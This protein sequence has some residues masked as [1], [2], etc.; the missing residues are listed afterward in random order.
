MDFL[1]GIGTIFASGIVRLLV[2][3]GTLLLVYLLFV[4]PALDT[5]DKA[6]QQFNVPDNSNQIQRSIQRSIRQTN[7][8]V[9]RQINRSFNQT[10]R[11]HGQ[12]R[13]LRCLRRAHENVARIQA[14][15]RRF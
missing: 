15:G 1:R 4:R 11:V 5:A 12:Q 7:R 8:Q 14:C 3:A 10:P 13:L 9:Q 2:V 6:F